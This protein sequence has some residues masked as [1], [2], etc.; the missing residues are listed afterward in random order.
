MIVEP[1]GAV[2][3]EL[4]AG[5]TA[6]GMV[7]AT[8]ATEAAALAALEIGAAPAVLVTAGAEN[9]LL[10][11]RS[12]EK[13]PRLAIVFTGPLQSQINLRGAYHLAAY[14]EPAKLSR[15]LRLVVARPALRSTLQ[16]RYRNARQADRSASRPEVSE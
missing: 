6:D 10:V 9:A 14:S 13:W 3:T 4:E 11:T 16:S 15:F 1:D 2:R 12:R 8:F 5:L 7:V